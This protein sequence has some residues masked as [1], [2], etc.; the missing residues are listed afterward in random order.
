MNNTDVPADPLNFAGRVVVVTG[1]SRGI[2]RAIAERFAAAGAIVFGFGRS[3]PDAPLGFEFR[4]C[5]VRDAGAVRAAIDA[6]GDAHGRIDVVVNNAGGSPESDAATASP[7]FAERIVALNLLAPLHVAQAAHRWMQAE[8][9][10]IVN[11][12]SVSATRPSPGTAVYAAAKAGLV[13]LTR[14]LA[15]E[16]GPGIRLNAIIVGYIATDDVETTYGGPAAQAAIADTLGLRRLGR[17]EEIAEAALFL[18]SPMA[19][20]VSGAA[21]AADG[22]NEWPSFLAI[23][24]AQASAS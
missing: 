14:S 19:S 21:L 24:K 16:W 23:L 15:Q 3:L 1:A 11:I 5:D 2:G 22:G 7:R 12:A 9:G 20:Y 17:P 13:Q 8:G 6:I 18:A 4:A 10:A